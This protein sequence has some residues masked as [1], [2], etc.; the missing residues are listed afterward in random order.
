MENTLAV[1]NHILQ[2][3]ADMLESGFEV[4]AITIRKIAQKANIAVGLVNYYYSKEEL[5]LQATHVVIDRVAA[6]EGNLLVDES[7]PPNERLRLFLKGI[8]AIVMQYES[9]S[10]I[11]L[12]QEVL[13]QS[14]ATPNHIL[15]ILKE[16]KPDASDDELKWLCIVV[17]APL[18]YIFLKEK[19]FKAYM[20]AD[21]T[22]TTEFI[23]HHLKTLGL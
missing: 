10:R 14:F 23:D 19:G 13:G 15:P 22:V 9:F 17:V 11:M 7:L 8:A 5:M 4:E 16:M 18:Q 21:S 1:K 6:K 20:G 3:T 12:R 2:V